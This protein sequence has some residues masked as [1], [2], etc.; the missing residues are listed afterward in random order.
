MNVLKSAR[1]LKQQILQLNLGQEV[2]ASV[3]L[4]DDVGQGSTI[5]VLVLN[6]HVV[7]FRPSRIIPHDVGVLS[8]NRVCVYLTKCI[9]SVRRQIYKL[10]RTFI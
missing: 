10:V 4:A 9:L 2:H 8:K 5:A 1:D 3:V 7:I 6:Q